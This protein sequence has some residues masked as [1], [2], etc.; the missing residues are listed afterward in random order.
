MKRS[1]RQAL[2]GPAG[3]RWRAAS[4]DDATA[5]HSVAAAAGALD[6]PYFTMPLEE[7]TA[8][9]AAISA[10]N[11]RGIV[12]SDESGRVIGFGT[13]LPFSLDA[14]PL[15]TLILGA[16]APEARRRGI[17]RRIIAWQRDQGFAWLGSVD[18]H[19]GRRVL[20]YTDEK[21]EDARRLLSA[22]GFSETREYLHLRRGTAV[23][24]DAP[25]PAGYTVVPLAE[26]Y[27]EPVRLLRNE[28]FRGQWGG[29]SLDPRE[30]ATFVSRPVFD[31]SLSR[32]MIDASD[33]VVG[34]TLVERDLEGGAGQGSASAYLASLGV[35]ESQRKR[36]LGAA[37]L[38]DL[39]QLA[40]QRDIEGV[41][42]DV[43]SESDSRA[44]ELY[45]RLGFEALHRRSSYTMEQTA[46]TRSP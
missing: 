33:R 21:A 26:P 3:V 12:A 2:E 18:P 43:D 32:V 36:G 29:H 11:G 27:H 41:T 10:G 6:H 45:F 31:E 19:R 30:W 44:N 8:D 22:A 13:V 28:A 1:D 24:L 9:L 7:I 17:G 38:G 39:V 35:D 37:L 20:T 14:S 23:P 40:D 15:V 42:L 34:Y 46:L 16:V 25:I 5:I 4:V